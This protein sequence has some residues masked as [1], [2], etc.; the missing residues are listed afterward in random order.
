MCY[1]L[2]VAA[3][4]VVAA[5]M[6]VPAHAQPLPPNKTFF[7]VAAP[8]I[9]GAEGCLPKAIGRVTIT[10]LGVVENMHV[11]ASG[12]PKNTDFDFFIIQV[13][14]SPFG[15]SWYMGD[16]LT[17][18]NGVAVGDFIGRFNLGTF[19]VAPGIAPAP[20]TNLLDANTNPVTPPVQMYHLGL[21]FDSPKDAA[22]SNCASKQTPF[23][24]T[25]NAGVQVLNTSNF[26]T[27]DGP[28]RTA[29]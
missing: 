5:A 3:L 4:S 26:P 27:L 15:L 23:N 19:V 29:P 2:R 6:S 8:G 25:H 1:A 18:P 22:A 24:S 28:L 20:V 10:T 17:D 16:M 9:G 21:W 13:P 7:M 12:L 11:E 14:L